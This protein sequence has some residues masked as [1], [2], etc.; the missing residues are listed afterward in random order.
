VAD[1]SVA[2]S[3]YVELSLRFQNKYSY[4]AKVIA[5]LLYRTVMNLETKYMYLFLRPVHVLRLQVLNI[6]WS[7]FSTM[8]CSPVII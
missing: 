6:F 7:V 3:L 1:K 5:L 2:S 8:V 4:N